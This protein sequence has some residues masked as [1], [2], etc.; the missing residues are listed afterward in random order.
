L[1]TTYLPLKGGVVVVVAS[2]A[3][4]Q[5]VVF[6]FDRLAGLRQ[7]LALYGFHA[8]ANTS[9]APH[10]ATEGNSVSHPRKPASGG[11][12]RAAWG[13]GIIRKGGAGCSANCSITATDDST[14]LTVA[15]GTITGSGTAPFFKVTGTWNTSAVAPAI[16]ADVT[17]TSGP[18]ALLAD[19]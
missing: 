2:S 11:R 4:S 9:G 6:I 12:L 5:L 3:S 7:A 8:Q 10:W 13:Q 18:A 15:A 19:F 1:L 14:G 16:L 17:K